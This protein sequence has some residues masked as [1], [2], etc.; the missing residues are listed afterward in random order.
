[1]VLHIWRAKTKGIH[2]ERM[3]RTKTALYILSSWRG[4][5]EKIRSNECESHTVPRSLSDQFASGKSLNFQR[6]NDKIL[7]DAALRI[8]ASALVRQIRADKMAS[9]FYNANLAERAIATWHSNTQE[10]RRLMKQ[11]KLVRRLFLERTIWRKWKEA[12]DAKR[13]EVKFHELEKKRLKA[14]WRTWAY[15]ARKARN[16]RRKEDAVSSTV[17]M[18][19]MRRGLDTWMERVLF[20]KNREYDVKMEYHEKLTRY[21]APCSLLVAIHLMPFPV[22]PL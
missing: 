5:L 7:V 17:T 9:K 22:L 15:R 2:V 21:V 12:I 4:R 20:I 18:R 13:R 14:T 16:D 11:A 1:M 8:W 19:L 10:K 6:R 3:K